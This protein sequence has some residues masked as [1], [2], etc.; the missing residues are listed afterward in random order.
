MDIQEAIDAA[1][2][3]VEIHAP[4]ENAEEQEVVD[5]V[6]ESEGE[7]PLAE[8]EPE[9]EPEGESEEDLPLPPGVTVVPT[10]Q[11]ELA[12]QFK[13]MDAEG[14]VEVPD[15]F[16]EYK[17]NGQV[18]KDRIDQVVKMAQWG[19]YN[20]EREQKVK[21]VEQEVLHAKQAAEEY[22]RLVIEREKQI[23]R[24]LQ[25]DDFLLTV[26]EAYE[27]EN[28]PEKR[29]ERAELDLQ[30]YKIQKEMEV[31]HQKGDAF[32]SAEVEPALGMIAQALPNV[33]V[34]DLEERL[35]YALQAHTETAP[36]GSPYVPESR[37]DAIRKFLLED[38]A[39]WAQIQNARRAAPTTEKAAASDE[40]KKARIEAQ[41][42]KRQ[43]GAATRPVG[44]TGGISTQKSQ[45]K[46]ETIDDA[47]DSALGSVL[48]AIS[49]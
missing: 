27:R 10:V 40:L 48:S 32:W 49:R 5:Q 31:I 12:T 2:E 17:A 20:E 36:D 23:E 3:A 26:R 29:A 1:M 35:F 13:I 24:L 30:S 43:L 8:G 9:G 21:L 22:E 33:P 38:L 7:A 34:Q 28:S 47:L 44:R 45:S 25:D 15:L 14:E 18:R 6:P 19:V 41:K 16:I 42:A 11:G 39:V 37:F 46:P 4:E